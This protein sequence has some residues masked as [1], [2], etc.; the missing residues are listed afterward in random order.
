VTSSSAPIANSY[1]VNDVVLVGPAPTEED[2]KALQLAGIGRI[3]NLMEMGEVGSEYSVGDHSMSVLRSPISDFGLPPVET[4]TQILDDIDSSLAGGTNVFV[5]CRA[6]VGRSG[7][8]VGCWLVR[9]G[10]D[11]EAA[12][13]AISDRRGQLSPEDRS[14]ETPDQRRFVLHWEAGQ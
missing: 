11:A 12:L 7:T 6:G 13:G 8:V 1:W 10:L 4:M 3:V 9:H 14:P 5:H 2:L